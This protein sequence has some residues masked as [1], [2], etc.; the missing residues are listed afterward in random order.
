MNINRLTDYAF[1]VLIFVAANDDRKVNLREIAD[2]YNVSIENLRKVVHTLAKNGYLKTQRGRGG[3]IEQGLPVRDLRLGEIFLIF[4][5][6]PVIDCFDIDCTLAGFCRLTGILNQSK[7][8][9]V[10]YLNN[11]SIGD[12]VVKQHQ[13]DPV[14]VPIKNLPS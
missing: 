9:F 11:Y 4:E 2:R 7:Q 12:L 13:I 14:M 8:E 1:R 10:D 3:G 5:P 6:M